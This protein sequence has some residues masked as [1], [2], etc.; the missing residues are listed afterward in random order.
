LLD[1]VARTGYFPMGTVDGVLLPEQI[2]ERI[3]GGRQ[4]K[5]PI[6]AGYN[7]GEIRSLRFLLPPPPADSGAYEA[8]IR[9]RYGDLAEAFL[10]HYP[11]DDLDASMLATTRDAL[12]GWSAERLVAGQRA[13]G[14]D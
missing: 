3:D 8:E 1:S 9:G 14:A 7:E 10:Q 12:Y 11:S 6:L 4:A 5:V 2:V 13:L